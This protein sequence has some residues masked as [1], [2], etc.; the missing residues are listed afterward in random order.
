MREK[1]CR[2][3]KREEGERGAGRGSERERGRERGEREVK[4]GEGQ[5]SIYF[6]RSIGCQLENEKKRRMDYPKQVDD[7]NTHMT[8]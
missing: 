8:I 1:G 7:R 5:K 2:E 4:K 3:C 6:E